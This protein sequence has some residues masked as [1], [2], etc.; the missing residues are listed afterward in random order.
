MLVMLA[1]L[2]APLASST[3]FISNA[4]A[5]LCTASVA[6]K[7]FK[8]PEAPTA[9]KCRKLS[10]SPPLGP[11]KSGQRAKPIKV[12]WITRIEPPVDCS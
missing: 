11:P 2:A 8:A 1:P 6:S 4:R 3:C 10:A 9:N 5:C 7:A 12:T